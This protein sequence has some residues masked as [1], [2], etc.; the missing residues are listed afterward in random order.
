MLVAPAEIF[1]T[2]ASGPDK[3]S[4]TSKLPLRD[5]IIPHFGVITH[6]L[7]RTK[8]S[9]VQPYTSDR[10]TQPINPLVHNT[11]DRD[12]EYNK[13]ACRTRRYKQTNKTTQYGKQ[14]MTN[15]NWKDD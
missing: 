14:E 12:D 15:C 6:P 10:S 3:W 2:S 4:R 1:L 13:Q 9:V 7:Q 11:L 8:R 5:S